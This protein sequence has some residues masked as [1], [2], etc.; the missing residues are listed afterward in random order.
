MKMTYLIEPDTVE[1]FEVEGGK[2]DVILRRNI[3]KVRKAAET[4]N[5]DELA[6]YDAWECDERQFR[7]DESI[8]ATK[9]REDFD[10]WWEYA[11][12]APDTLDALLEA[13]ANESDLTAIW[14][15]LRVAYQEGVNS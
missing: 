7:L 1:T 15:S 6:T 12:P 14:T 13:K 3:T 10:T 11:T 9:F 2:T 4:D 5:S 8:T